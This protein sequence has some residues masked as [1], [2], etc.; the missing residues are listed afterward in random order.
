MQLQHRLQQYTSQWNGRPAPNLW[1]PEEWSILRK[2]LR[3]L[4]KIP[5]HYSDGTRDNHKGKYVKDLGLSHGD[6]EALRSIAI[7]SH[8]LLDDLEALSFGILAECGISDRGF[9]IITSLQH[10]MSSGINRFYRMNE[11]RDTPI[12][13]ACDVEGLPPA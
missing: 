6:L 2:P 4:R 10:D 13:R 8:D 7:F 1:E 3:A 12:V 11:L 5:L 9:S